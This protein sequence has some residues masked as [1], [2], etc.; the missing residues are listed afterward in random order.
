[1]ALLRFLLAVADIIVYGWR[2][3]TKVA[4]SVLLASIETD[5]CDTMK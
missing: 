5:V 1:V 4:S 3:E 2:D